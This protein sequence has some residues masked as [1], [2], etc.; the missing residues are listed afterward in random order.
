M[1][2]ALAVLFT[3]AL[4]AP[5]SASAGE[6]I[7][8]KP[9]TFT[10]GGLPF[11]QSA[12]RNPTGAELGE[13]GP[14]GALRDTIR[15]FNMEGPAGAELPT[16]GWRVLART[17][18]RVEFQTGRPDDDGFVGWYVTAE[19]RDG[20]WRGGSLGACGA[21]RVLDGHEAPGLR[22][23]H[24]TRPRRRTRTLTL[25]ITTGNCGGDGH[26]ADRFERI[27]VLETR[28][29]VTL[30]ALMRPEPELPPDTA[31]PAIGYVFREKVRLARPLG[32]RAIRDASRF[33]ALEI[34]RALSAPARK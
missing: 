23:A 31:C 28:H 7:L 8:G 24:D 14:A 34:G 12:F 21:W 27:E 25:E 18:D 20:H 30:L 2:R 6:R 33:P 22:L 17:P 9:G 32:R 13:D 5:A 15:R 16:R 1:S 10:C 29:T 26:P 4:V 19:L 3:L 11:P